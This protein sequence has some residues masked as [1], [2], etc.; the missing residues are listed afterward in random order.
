MKCLV[1]GGAGF[2]GSNLALDLEHHGHEVMIIDN[3]FSGAMENLRE[4]KGTFLEADI[5][6]PI[7]R[8]P[9]FDAI[10]HIASITDPRFVDDKYLFEKNL[11]GF[12]NMVALAR[13]NRA[14]LVYAS[15]ASVYGN[16][17][18]PMREDQKKDPFSAY[19]K[20]KL[21]MDEIADRLA[22]SMHIVGLRYFNVYG[23]RESHKGRPASM[24]YHLMDQMIRGHARIFSAGE[25]RRDHV[26]VNDVITATLCA[27]DAPSGVYNVGTGRGISFNE[28]VA[29]LNEVLKTTITPE[30]IK[31]PYEQYQANTQ[32]ETSRAEN[33]LHFRAKYSLIDGIREYHE[34]LIREG[35]FPA[36]RRTRADTK[37]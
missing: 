3:V 33:L 8:Q 7:P 17:P 35:K 36:P 22:S 31:N 16:G 34:W 6:E 18:I 13:G 10:F 32:A 14:K 2:I 23:P 27:L 37:S 11:K 1:T 12:K 19:A 30:Y 20:S 28:V 25:Q 29:A 24:I 15:S 21:A 26:Y 4:F 5:A 9:R